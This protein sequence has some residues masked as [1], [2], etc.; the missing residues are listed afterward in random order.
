MDSAGLA[1]ADADNAVAIMNADIGSRLGFKTDALCDY[2]K[3]QF[4]ELYVEYLF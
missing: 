3:V 4:K 2:A 1:C